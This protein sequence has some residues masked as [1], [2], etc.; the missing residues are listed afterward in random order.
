MIRLL[1]GENMYLNKAYTFMIL[2]SII[3]FGI[4]GYNFLIKE[5]E[6]FFFDRVIYME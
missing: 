6:D 4:V 1:G 2:K 5:K 3:L